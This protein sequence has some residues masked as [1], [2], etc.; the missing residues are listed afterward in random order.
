LNRLKLEADVLK[1]ASKVVDSRILELER[2][3]RARILA[4]DEASR[5][6]REASG[7]EVG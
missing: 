6:A 2:R 5:S 1:N 4:K 7:R 3:K